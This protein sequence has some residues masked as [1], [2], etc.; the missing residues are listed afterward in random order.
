M[1]RAMNRAPEPSAK[2]QGVTGP[3]D[4]A[5][6]G[7]GRARADAA[8]RRI[9]ALGQAVDLIVEQQDLAIEV[10]AQH[11][12]RVVAADRQ[13]VAVA[14]DDP[15]VELGVGELDAGRDRRRAAVDRVEAV[16]RHVIRKAARAADAADEHRLLARD[17]E[18]GHR[19]LH[20]LQHRII[21][22]ARAPAD[23]LVAR[24]V[25]GGGDGW[26]HVVHQCGLSQMMMQDDGDEQDHHRPDVDRFHANV[27]QCSHSRARAIPPPKPHRSP[28]RSRRCGT[29]WPETFVSDFASTRNWSRSTVLNWPMFI[30][31]T[32]ICLKP[33]NRTD[34]FL[35][36]GQMWRTWTWAT[37]CPFGDRAAHRLVDRAEGRAPA[38]DRQ[39][40]AFAAEAHLLVGNRIGDAEHLGGAGVGHLL[41]DFG[42]IIDVAGARLLLDA[43]DAVL[44]AGRAGPDP[45]PRELVVARVGHDP[46]AFRRAACRRS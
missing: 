28:P 6:R 24:P 17:A 20:G 45:R 46:L 31:G 19:P 7:R 1:P 39:L 18:V 13:R 43:A 32:R 41:V 9:L 33:F 34:I 26:R 11:V 29:G 38:D 2:A 21:A 44:E 16:A 30:S 12:H 42:P 36:I 4:R 3:V 5:E 25:L 23:L 37:S 35:G 10:A 15:H 22:A 27:R 14:G 8:G 40:G